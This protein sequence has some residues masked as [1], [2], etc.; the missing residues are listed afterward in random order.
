MTWTDWSELEPEF[1][2][3]EPTYTLD[4]TDFRVYNYDH[5]DGGPT[6]G[7]YE[8]DITLIAYYDTKEEAQQAAVQLA[9]RN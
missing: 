1:G 4:G 9:S 6:W 3:S 8:G 7:L 5:E 2:A